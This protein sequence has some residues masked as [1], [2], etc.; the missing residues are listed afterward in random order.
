MAVFVYWQTE[1]APRK[2]KQFKGKK[3]LR[4]VKVICALKSAKYF[5]VYECY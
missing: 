5:A 2:T 1:S 3:L 4:L